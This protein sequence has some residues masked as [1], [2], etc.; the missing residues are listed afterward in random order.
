[1]PER[2]ERGWTSSEGELQAATVKVT[3]MGSM[4]R[5]RLIMGASLGSWLGVEVV[6]AHLSDD[7]AVAKM[8]TRSVVTRWM[9]R[10][11]GLRRRR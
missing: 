2:A 4:V 7:E 3:T 1:L 11:S 10:V 9:E 5:A 6:G 8:G